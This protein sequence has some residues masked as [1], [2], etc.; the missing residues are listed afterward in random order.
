MRVVAIGVMLDEAMV[1]IVEM[2]VML[3]GRGGSNTM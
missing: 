3:Y 1:E 2:V